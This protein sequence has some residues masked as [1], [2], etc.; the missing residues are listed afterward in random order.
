MALG[1]VILLTWALGGVLR[2]HEGR[3]IDGFSGCV[4]GGDSL[5]AELLAMKEGINLAW[6]KGITSLICETDSLEVVQNLDHFME[7]TLHPHKDILSLIKEL[8]RRDWQVSIVHVFR[9]AN[10]VADKL[11][12][13]GDSVSSHVSFWRSPPPS[14]KVLIDQDILTAN[15]SLC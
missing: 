14:V 13:L 10:M 6:T 11:S 12:R 2:D 7:T 1:L 4:A 5:R 3:W 8:L 9:E 15:L